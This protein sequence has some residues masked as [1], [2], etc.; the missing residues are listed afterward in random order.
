MTRREGPAA[1]VE[2][3]AIPRVPWNQ[4]RLS[5]GHYVFHVV[6]EIF[7]EVCCWVVGE[8]VLY[9][10]TLGRSKSTVQKMNQ[11]LLRIRLVS[12]FGLLLIVLFAVLMGRLAL[13]ET[14][15][16]LDTPRRSSHNSPMISHSDDVCFARTASETP[17]RTD[18]G[19]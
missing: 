6:V 8:F 5:L 2:R 3:R 11:T 13:G 18:Y 12:C 9:C 7:F 15:D 4:R 17:R 19:R 16:R 14:H 1:S 10:L